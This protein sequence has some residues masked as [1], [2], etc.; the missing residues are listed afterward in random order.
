MLRRA[1]QFVLLSAVA[2]ALGCTMCASP[3]DD[4]GPVF[5]GGCR[6]G[7]ST[8]VRAGS[9]LSQASAGEV[10]FEEQGEGRT[11]S[12]TDRKAAA[13]EGQPTVAPKPPKPGAQKDG[14][15][16]SDAPAGKVKS[17]GGLKP[18]DE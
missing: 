17:S 6:E 9:V 10:V 16:S 12:T 13:G 14:W 7:C 8:G 2:S 15:K 5:S 4:C 11:L 3:Y 18:R 1:V